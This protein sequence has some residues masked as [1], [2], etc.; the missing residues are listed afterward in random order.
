M[1]IAEYLYVDHTR[2]DS[3][4]E[5]ISGSVK[6][7]KVPIWKV[8]LGLTGLSVE[9]TQQRP[10][11]PFTE[12]EKLSR[13]AATLPEEG[14][15]ALFH[16][17]T[18][19]GRRTVIR[20]DKNTLRG[21]AFWLCRRPQSTG[22]G[23]YLVEQPRCDD[24]PIAYYSGLTALM[25]ILP[26]IH[27]DSGSDE[28][29]DRLTDEKKDLL[30]ARLPI[31]I[32]NE[33]SNGIKADWKRI[34]RR[35]LRSHNLP[36]SDDISID[37]LS[38]DHTYKRCGVSS[39]NHFYRIRMQRGP[40]EHSFSV[41]V[42]EDLPARFDANPIKVLQERGFHVGPERKIDTL[43]RVRVNAMGLILGYPV[44]IAAHPSPFSELARS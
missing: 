14:P 8:A 4:F 43:F 15:E 3:Y 24:E 32:W 42:D 1:E 34:L 19:F 30:S 16:L 11:R 39:G 18:I 36:L 37:R 10:A 33:L 44:F 35:L 21:V 41:C 9:S 5:Q 20:A 28:Q 17:M 31:E 26:I 27:S 2:T 38:N 22:I 29:I 6:Y 12:H 7:D 25:M 40:D 23:L 13:L